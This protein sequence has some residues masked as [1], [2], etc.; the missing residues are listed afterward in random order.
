MKFS[1]FFAVLL[2]AS[3][4]R[5]DC[6]PDD[7]ECGLS[8]VE[9][10]QT[11]SSAPHIR[12]QIVE[13]DTKTPKVI[14]AV[15]GIAGGLSLV[16]SWTL[17]VARANYRL[18]PRYTVDDGVMGKWEGLGTAALVTGVGGAAGL[19]VAEALLLPESTTV[20]TLAWIGGAV[21][22]G[23]A[24]V[25]VGFIAGGTHCPPLAIRPG[26]DIPTACLSGTSDTLFGTTL[27][28]TAAPLMAIPLTYLFRDLF[29]GAPE[30]LTLNGTGL[31]WKGRF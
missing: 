18:S 31:Q 26:S 11:P 3:I 10:G 8:V 25:G 24:A 29:A 6:P 27:L 4:A 23:A 13:H 19:I 5:A 20:P 9:L 28:L 21:G 1:A 14:G 22:L 2:L 17:Y 12:S 16:A 15:S 30:S 7:F